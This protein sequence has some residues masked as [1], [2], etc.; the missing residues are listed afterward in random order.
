MP[1]FIL[2]CLT[3]LSRG[4]SVKISDIF[5]RNGARNPDIEGDT[6]FALDLLS[7]CSAESQSPTEN[8]VISPVSVFTAMGMVGLGSDGKTQ[9]QFLRVFGDRYQHHAMV[10][11]S[12]LERIES[13]VTIAN[14]IFQTGDVREEF[15]N[16]LA[17]FYKAE[18][19]TDM[20]KAAINKW[21]F[22]KT[23]GKI[24]QIIGDELDGTTKAVVVNAI[25]LKA[26]WKESFDREHSRMGKFNQL[27][28][29]YYMKKNSKMDYLENHIF[30]AVGLPYEGNLEM[31]VVL[32][33][34]SS[35]LD[36][37]MASLANDGQA[38]LRS[39]RS[40]EVSLSLPRMKLEYQIEMADVL[41][42]L[43]LL[44]AFNPAEASFP[45]ISDVPLYISNVY[46]KVIMDVDEE[47]T[48]AAA[49]TAV[50]IRSRMKIIRNTMNVNRPFLMIVRTIS[51]HLPVFMALV[52]K[53][54]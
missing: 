48:V 26:K 34:P 30:Q 15:S 18:V 11:L 3:L 47:G 44:D 29:V 6:S 9:N 43:G 2:L 10:Q 12:A 7:A 36:D 24:N 23:S 17:H 31:V 4:Y 14:A 19:R 33:K 5:Q 54:M 52:K 46:H 40:Q 27:H 41:K 38:G 39:F 32:P 37:V 35:S 22:E 1:L 42:R 20:N 16:E 13:Q 8:V 21:C 53:P 45:K 25:Y 51:E 49:V 50:K 28:D